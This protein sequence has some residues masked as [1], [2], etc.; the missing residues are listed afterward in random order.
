MSSP[1]AWIE[2]DE[3]ED[4]DETEDDTTLEDETEL[5]T[6]LE[7]LEVAL[8]STVCEDSSL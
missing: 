7:A 2:E 5:D 6:T 1:I 3:M 4:D 8:F